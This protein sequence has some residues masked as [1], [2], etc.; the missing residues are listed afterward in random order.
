MIALLFTICLSADMT[1]CE[2]KTLSFSPYSVSLMTC[3]IGAQ[4][5]LAEWSES[6][7]KHQVV[8]WKCVHNN[9]NQEQDA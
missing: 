3:M 8:E 4:Q 5:Y 9:G 1:A 2:E 7:P 6:H